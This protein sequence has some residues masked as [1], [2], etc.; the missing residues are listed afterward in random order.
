MDGVGQSAGL[1]S[2]SRRLP[3]PKRQRAIVTGTAFDQPLAGVYTSGLARSFQKRVEKNLLP[4][5][6]RCCGLYIT[7]DVIQDIGRGFCPPRE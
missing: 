4:I 3:L 2:D 6:H 5:C 1:L 7:N